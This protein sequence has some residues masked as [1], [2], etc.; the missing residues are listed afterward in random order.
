LLVRVGRNTPTS[1]GA[2]RR[3][4]NRFNQLTGVDDTGDAQRAPEGAA[5]LRQ[6]ETSRIGMEM[7]SPARPPTGR[8][9]LCL[10]VPR[11]PLDRDDPQ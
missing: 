6:R 11:Q 8:I 9:G 1:G 7:C 10:N 5:S 3:G 2:G 4:A